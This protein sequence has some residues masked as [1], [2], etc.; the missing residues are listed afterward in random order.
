MRR[1]VTRDDIKERRKA[2]ICHSLYNKLHLVARA[3]CT[4]IELHHS[5]YIRSSLRARL[6]ECR[7]YLVIETLPRR[8]RRSNPLS[9]TTYTIGRSFASL[10]LIF[11][12]RFE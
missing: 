1:K 2:T 4:L 6:I 3:V 10:L 11:D 9:S 12:T 7:M 8:R 5:A